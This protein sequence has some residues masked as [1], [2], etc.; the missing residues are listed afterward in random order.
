MKRY[1]PFCLLLTTPYLLWSQLER[2]EIIE[3]D[4]Y[5]RYP[6]ES[7]IDGVLIYP[8]EDVSWE[9]QTATEAAID[10]TKL[11]QRETTTPEES[12]KIGRSNNAKVPPT[13]QYDSRRIKSSR[14]VS[15]A[16][17]RVP[18]TNREYLFITNS[19]S[20]TIVIEIS[21][22]V[23]KEIDPS[24]TIQ[25]H[26]SKF[27]DDKMFVNVTFKNEDTSTLVFEAFVNRPE[28]TTLDSYTFSDGIR[29]EG[30]AIHMSIP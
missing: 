11:I 28:L 19:S 4:G 25:I 27:T 18:A 1:L 16:R 15:I 2:Y 13:D 14:D 24:K 21:D 20:Y 26:K 9:T 17:K 6:V 23:Q 7:L 30:G 22:I 3:I 12:R 5:E 29:R 10:T 8:A